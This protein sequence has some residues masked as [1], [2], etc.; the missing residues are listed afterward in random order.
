MT[1]LSLLAGRTVGGSLFSYE[2]VKSRC[3]FC[4]LGFKCCMQCNFSDF[5]C[6]LLNLFYLLTFQTSLSDRNTFRVPN[7]LDPY[8]GETVFKCY[9]QKTK[10]ATSKE[11]NHFLY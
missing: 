3:F 7:V 8:L 10:V 9:Q 4:K 11:R 2:A 1:S 5:C 6:C